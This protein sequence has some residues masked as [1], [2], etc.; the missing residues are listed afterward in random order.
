[1]TKLLRMLSKYDYISFDIFDTL[2]KR[3]VKSPSD[4]FRLVE[5]VYNNNYAIDNQ[6]KIFNFKQIR[7][8]AL[9]NAERQYNKKVC[10]LDEIYECIQIDKAILEQLKQIEIETELEVCVCNYPI[11]EVFHMLKKKGK[12]LILISDMYLSSTVLTK[13]LKKCGI[14][15]YD[16]LFV[17]CEYGCRKTDGTLYQMVCRKIG[18]EPSQIAH[19]GDGWKNDIIRAKQNK[20][21]TFH[22]P[23]VVNQLEYYS[24]RG[25]SNEECFTYDTLLTIANNNISLAKSEFEKLG[26][27]T[28][29]PLVYGFTKWLYE[30]LKNEHIHKVFFLAREGKIIKEVFDNLFT[31]GTIQTEYFYASR[32]SIIIPSYWVEP[33]FEQVCKSMSMS[34]YMTIRDLFSRWNLNINCYEKELKQLDLVPEYTFHGRKIE[35]NLKIRKLYELL[36]NDINMRSKEEYVVLEKYLDSIEFNGKVAIVDIGWNG[37]MQKAMEK[38]PYVTENGMEIH[39]YYFG[40]NSSSLKSSL[41]HIHGYIYENEKNLNYRYLIYGFAGPLELSLTAEHG[42]THHYELCDGKV[43]PVLSAHEYINKQG[44]YAKELKC[45]CELQTGIR[46]FINSIKEQKSIRL[47]PVSSEIAFHDYFK[48]ATCP[49]RKHILMY[50]NF[51]AFDL[52]T[53]Q[54]FIGSQYKHLWGQY[55]IKNGLK[56]STWKI[57]FMKYIFR[58]PFPYKNIYLFMRKRDI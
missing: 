25:L 33:D 7:E 22:I 43:M 24:R 37:G 48:F 50:E 26:I 45:T 42:S 17:S 51:Q 3:N 30:S 56:L 14:N 47:L 10:S 32:R 46:I 9:L 20:L 12:K 28:L 53:R 34:K 13:M 6:D 36:K 54:V 5:K 40:I 4:V 11:A 39:G 55:S 21:K 58:L 19:V 57:G 35:N 31:D 1:M 8:K 29:G 2:I 18:V 15:E 27:E 23:R 41:N 44:N 52:K 49:K 16:F 38:L